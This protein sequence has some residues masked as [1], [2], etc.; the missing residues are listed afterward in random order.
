MRLVGFGLLAIALVAVTAL[1]GVHG[2]SAFGTSEATSVEQTCIAVATARPQITEATMAVQGRY[3]GVYSY[4]DTEFV[5]GEAEPLPEDCAQRVGRELSYTLE[6]QG[7]T[8]P[9]FWMR[10]GESLLSEEPDPIKVKDP[11]EGPEF[12]S[13]SNTQSISLLYVHAH[14]ARCRQKQQ[15]CYDELTPHHL[16]V[17]QHLAWG[18]VRKGGLYVCSNPRLRPP[19]LRARRGTPGPTKARMIFHSRATRL[20]GHQ[21]IAERNF[22]RSLT[23]KGAC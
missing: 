18:I 1:I 5:K 16:N 10:R 2:A 13:L 12:G 23:V 21:V 15:Q 14:E 9:N 11:F 4:E 22:V 7:A 8:N 17:L 20:P 19:L 3:K 6:V